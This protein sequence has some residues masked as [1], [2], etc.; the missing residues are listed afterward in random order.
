MGYTYRKE[1]SV[2]II[3]YDLSEKHKAL[4]RANRIIQPNVLRAMKRQT[5]HRRHKQADESDSDEGIGGSIASDDEEVEGSNEEGE[6]DD[7][8]I[9]GSEENLNLPRAANGM[10]KSSRGRN[11]RIMPVAEVR[12]HLRRVFANEPIICSLLYGRHGANVFG[13]DG[14]PTTAWDLP[15]AVADIFFMEVVPVPPTRFRPA[16]KMGDMLFESAQNTLLSKV[17][18]AGGTI[19]TLNEKLRGLHDIKEVEEDLEVIAKE[20]KVR[21]YTQL[22]EAIYQLQHEVNSFLDSSKN[23]TIMR[24]GALPPNG[25]KQVLEKKDGLFRKHMMVSISSRFGENFLTTVVRVNESTLRHDPSSHPTSTSRLTR[26]VSPPFSLANSLT[27]NRS[28]HT[29]STSCGSSS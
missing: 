28:L 29:T 13:A 21:V 20:E 19:A 6:G 27:R 2:K 26:S 14:K 8:G 11:E 24:G 18:V 3:E 1:G 9:D 25:V 15:P 7:I 10:I 22:L 12:A 4:N 23:P 5:P 16:S 17:L